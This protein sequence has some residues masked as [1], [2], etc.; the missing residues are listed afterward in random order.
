[1]QQRA[2]IANG[3]SEAIC[4]VDRLNGRTALDLLSAGICASRFVSQGLQEPE[5]LRDSRRSC[6][7]VKGHGL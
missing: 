5:R 2:R 1:M 3:L 6:I 7:V 4:D